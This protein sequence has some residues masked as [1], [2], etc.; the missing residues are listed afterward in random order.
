MKQVLFGDLVTQ[1]PTKKKWK[2]S[3]LHI[4]FAENVEKIYFVTGAGF[5]VVFCCFFFKI[6]LFYFDNI[7]SE[8][9]D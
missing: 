1:T 9:I 2:K 8:F 4:L 3:A 6:L 5:Y 7:E